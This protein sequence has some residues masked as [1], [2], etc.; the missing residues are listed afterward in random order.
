MLPLPKCLREGEEEGVKDELAL[1]QFH[2]FKS[3]NRS[4][5]PMAGLQWEDIMGSF[6]SVFIAYTT[7]QPAPEL[8]AQPL[9][10]FF[11]FMVQIRICNLLSLHLLYFQALCPTH[12][13][14]CGFQFVYNKSLERTDQGHPSGISLKFIYMHSMGIFI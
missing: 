6:V 3:V 4:L 12:I 9:A 5:N 11:Q 13:Y 10:S 1:A 8:D 7:F 14:E 2:D